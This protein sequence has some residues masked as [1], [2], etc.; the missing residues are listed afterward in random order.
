MPLL[1]I[2]TELEDRPGRL[3][4][5]TAALAARRANILDLS[6]QIG[7]DGVVDELVVDVPPHADGDELASAIES[8]GGTRVALTTAE[9]R[10]LID[11]TTRALTLVA[12]LR[13]D[14]TA[15]PQALAELLRADM[16]AWVYG[17]AA[18]QRPADALTVPVGHLRAV[19]LRRHGLPFT[20]T[21]AARAGALVRAVRPDPAPGR[22]P[23]PISL[24]DG[25]Q[26]VV[27]PLEAR[28]DAAVREM[29]E[30]CSGESRRLSHFSATPPPPTAD[31]V[32][33]PSPGPALVA[34]GPDGSILALAHLIHTLDPGVA[35]PAFLVEDHWQGRGLGRALAELLTAMARERGIVELRTS[36]P[37]ENIRMRGLLTS[38]GGRVGRAGASSAVEIRVRIDDRA[39]DGCRGGSARPAGVP[40]RGAGRRC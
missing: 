11:E 6:V 28:D 36:V 9:P 21:E 27:R 22:A 10:E 18:E 37:S 14:P 2:R 31:A 39:A 20:V 3:A 23:L 15:L 5:L 29:H 1:R 17:A 24:R 26:V 33:A 19:R 35:E 8:V 40:H 13:A 38:L 7:T 30:R 4:A 34:E 25:T 16:A 32:R 12:R